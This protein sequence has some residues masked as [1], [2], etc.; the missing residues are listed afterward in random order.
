MPWRNPVWEMYL[1]WAI[2]SA[3]ESVR[4]L[5]QAAGWVPEA[6]VKKYRI[7]T[8]TRALAE[9]VLELRTTNRAMSKQDAADWIN[10]LCT[11]DER[12]RLKR[13]W[14]P[15]NPFTEQDIDNAWAAMRRAEGWPAWNEDKLPLRE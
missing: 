7:R 15:D 4:N 1:K 13:R 8:Y 10:E 2:E 3:N 12:R 14:G 6:P 9:K 5:M 11:D